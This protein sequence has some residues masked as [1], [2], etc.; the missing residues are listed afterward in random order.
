M[1]SQA[2][3]P[4]GLAR[5]GARELAV[6][7]GTRLSL[8]HPH[9]LAA[10]IRRTGRVMLTGLATV[11]AACGAD[12]KNPAAPVPVASI[13]LSTNVATVVP[14]QTLQLT[15]TVKDASGNTLNGRVVSWASSDESKLRVD[16][17]GLLTGVAPGAA[18]I[19]AISEGRTARADVNVRDGGL[20]G[21]TG[22][23]VSAG[24]G[25]VTLAVPAGATSQP[26][27]V[28][29]DPAVS[30]PQDPRAV[31]GAAFEF[32]PNGAVFAQPVSLTLRY[33]PSG[34]GNGSPEY[35]L[36]LFKAVGT[37]WQEVAG[38]TVDTAAN[39]VTAPISSFSTYAV[40]GRHAVDRLEIS[41]PGAPV[42][43]GGTVQLSATVL[44]AAG[45][46]L[47]DRVVAWVSMHPTVASVDANGLARGESPGTATIQASAE[48]KHAT[49][50]VIVIPAGISLA[51]GESRTFTASQAA[52]IEISGGSAGAEFVM[53]PLHG[54]QTPAATVALEFNATNITGVSGPPLPSV[55]PATPGQLSVA[56][57]ASLL[58]NAGAARF[59]A[60]LRR[61]E[62]D[63]FARRIPAARAA[64]SLRAS[65]SAAGSG[66]L[67][68]VPAVGDQVSYNTSRTPCT[69]ASM[70][71]GTVVAVTTHAVVVA[72]NAN[73]AGG[74]TAEEYASIGQQFDNLV[75]PVLTANFGT[76][77][78]I[79]ANGARSVVFY[80]RAVNE[81]TPAGSNFVIGGF[82]HPRDLFPKVGP[83]PNSTDDDCATSNEAEMF[84]MLVPDPNGE[85]NGNVR[86]KESVRRTTVGV[87][88]HEYQHLINAARRIYVNNASSFE[89]VWLNEGLSHIAEELLFYRASGLAPRQN[90]T[91]STLR[92][93]QTIL[94]A[95]NA[96]QVSNFGRLIEYLEDPEGRSPYANDD[97]LATRGA[98]W[99]LLRYA[100]D[101]S[102]T[103][104]QTLWFNLANSRTTGVANFTAVFGGEFIPLVRDWATAQY[105]DDAVATTATLQHPSWHY[106]SI[107]PALLDP[108]TFPLKTRTL[109]AGTPLSLTLKGGSAAYLR[110]GVGGDATGRI[111]PTSSGAAL[112]AAVSVT[113]VR[114]R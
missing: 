67:S 28:T 69:S 26:I 43:V 78:D 90:I 38:S 34:I 83:D 48:G 25:A 49:V 105:T 82:F 75:H 16:A 17:T 54:S 89:E 65:A 88:G 106:R 27:A 37:G 6:A 96:Y 60:A 55:G 35:A 87:T 103:T 85:V 50:Q 71:A 1:K 104:Q 44:D 9:H 107:L 47:A 2:T 29:V 68:A 32:G 52:T 62:R 98:T 42:T 4:T 56:S 21:A 46:A 15:A 70:R 81:L 63:V 3:V 53:V 11:V 77:T 23:T 41:V 66:S 111:T 19:T 31:A 84:Y 92:S 100:A 64:R 108:Q 7:L 24:N 97:E 101:R 72:D 61:L 5:R 57:G 91:L 36:K 86:T 110:F 22:G 12:G 79:D 73:P 14:A 59:D 10:H 58:A 8:A 109:V 113:V 80:T 102:S 99:Q 95:V 33:Q 112:P 114:T 40:L 76:P 18:Q 20:I 94:D 39:A 13:T 51:V 30:A 93:S 45:N 74:F